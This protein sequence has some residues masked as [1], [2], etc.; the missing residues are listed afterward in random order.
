[1]SNHSRGALPIAIAALLSGSLS[2][3][4]GYYAGGFADFAPLASSAGPT[5]YEGKPITFG[6]P[7]F[8]QVTIASPKRPT[9][10]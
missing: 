5:N 8:R 4:D 9:R 6:N 3:A 10:R 2:Y 1:M 7:S